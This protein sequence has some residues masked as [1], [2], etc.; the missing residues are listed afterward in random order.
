M[1]KSIATTIIG[2]LA[3]A[4]IA[5]SA[6]YFTDSA[7]KTEEIEALRIESGEMSSRNE[8]LNADV[9][10]R[11]ASI[12]GLQGEKEEQA[13]LIDQLNTAIEEKAGQI[14]ALAA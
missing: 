10:Q 4:A 14:D 2:I 13:A 7:R 6:L 1:K 8:Q 9:E 3:I 5:I 12:R 11:D